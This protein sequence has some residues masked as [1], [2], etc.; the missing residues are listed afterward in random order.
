MNTV[1]EMGLRAHQAEAV[2]KRL[3]GMGYQVDVAQR[4]HSVEAWAIY[5]GRTV[6]YGSGRDALEALRSL[7][8]DLG[9]EV[10]P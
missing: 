9:V 5:N 7:A 1:H 10:Q 2:R 4:R 3:E 8:G 6:G